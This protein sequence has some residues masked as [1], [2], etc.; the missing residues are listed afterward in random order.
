MHLT[1]CFYLHHTQILFSLW[2]NQASRQ[3]KQLKIRLI[4]PRYLF[5]IRWPKIYQSKLH[6]PSLKMESAY[7]VSLSQYSTWNND[8]VE[9]AIA[10]FIELKKYPKNRKSP[11]YGFYWSHWHFFFKNFSACVNRTCFEV[12]G[13]SLLY[14]VLRLVTAS[15]SS[16]HFRYLIFFYRRWGCKTFISVWTMAWIRNPFCIECVRQCNY[17]S[18]FSKRRKQKGCNSRLKPRR[19]LIYMWFV[20]QKK[21]CYTTYGPCLISNISTRHCQDGITAAYL[22]N[23]Y[24][25]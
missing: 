7:T 2:A 22:Y 17:T 24:L 3:M 11:K 8:I 5:W 6:K 20:I 13:R 19:P 15:F 16:N 21:K 23:S 25:Y 14:V 9:W 18:L 4:Q 1:V 12:K 10:I